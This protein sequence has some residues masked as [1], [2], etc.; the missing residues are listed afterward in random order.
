MWAYGGKIMSKDKYTSEELRE[1]DRMT[2]EMGILMFYN[3]DRRYWVN[4]M[5]KE[6]YQM[7]KK[8]HKKGDK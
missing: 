1:F 7:G 6:A 8:A 5:L 2:N 4:R 3:E